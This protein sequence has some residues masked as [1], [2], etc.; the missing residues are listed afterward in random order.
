MHGSGDGLKIRPTFVRFTNAGDL[1]SLPGVKFSL[2]PLFAIA[3]SNAA[4]L[5]QTTI[6]DIIPTSLKTEHAQ[7]AEPNIAVD[8]S[9]PT[10]IVISVFGAPTNP[11]FISKD[12]GTAW[13]LLQKVPAGDISVGWGGPFNAY[14]TT[15]SPKATSIATLRLHDPTIRSA[16]RGVPK[17]IYK[18]GGDGPD[19][20][21][22]EVAFVNGVDRI[23][24]AFNDLSQATRTA[25]VHQSLDGGLTWQNVVLERQNPGLGFDGAAV[26]VAINGDR[27]YG[28]LQRFNSDVGSAIAG[29]IVVVRDDAGG[30]GGY[31]DLG[32]GGVGVAV[33]TGE[34]LPQGSLGQERLGSDLSI[35]VDPND[36]D[37]VVVAY[38]VI[39]AGATLVSLNLSSNAGVTWN[40]IFTTSGDS[41]LPAVAI[42]D[43]GVIGLLYTFYD[44]TNLET[45]FVQSPDEFGTQTDVTLSK[46]SDQSLSPDFDPYIGDYEDVV[47][48]GDFFYGT[49]SA[50]NDTAAF[51]QQPIFLRDKTL[52]GSK[53]VPFSIDPFF[54]KTPALP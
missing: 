52:L 21:W 43:N 16:F 35:A 1:F 14:M 54:F 24:V 8:P 32:T 2:L 44:G 4:A 3:L 45:H 48:V 9:D 29:D 15:L 28:A 51:P 37:R 31:S 42:A 27:V 50:S 22:T 12:G 53:K 40:E 25:S 17:S 38:A 13:A 33:A 49:F 18:P 23:Y 19:Q 30:A 20:P 41:A 5:S 26:R 7:N 47:A 10:K 39:R 46:F 36:P 11:I 6:I 34:R